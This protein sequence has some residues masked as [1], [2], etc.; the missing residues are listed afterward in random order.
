M[1]TSSLLIADK[2]IGTNDLTSS[3]AST[4]PLAVHAL[5]EYYIAL[6]LFSGHA[7]PQRLTISAI[8]HEENTGLG[9]E[10]CSKSS[11]GESIFCYFH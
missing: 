9:L 6:H 10:K 7:D 2:G 1:G 3:C 5:Q 11:D 8:I 4:M